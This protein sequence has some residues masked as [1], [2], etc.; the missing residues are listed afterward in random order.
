MDQRKHPTNTNE[1]SLWPLA[2]SPPP[3][4]P[5]SPQGAD[6]APEALQLQRPA[7]PEQQ[8][9]SA[10]GHPPL[11]DPPV[12]LYRSHASPTQPGMERPVRPVRPPQVNP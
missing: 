5:V 3:P 10:G 1:C 7:V 6:P 8:A 9:G 2:L 4:P 11:P 12:P